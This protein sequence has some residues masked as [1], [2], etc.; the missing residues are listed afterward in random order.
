MFTY[1]IRNIL[2]IIGIIFS[3]F[4][5]PDG[6]LQVFECPVAVWSVVRDHLCSQRNGGCVLLTTNH[7][8]ETRFNQISC[9][10]SN[11][12]QLCL[13]CCEGY[14]R[15]G[16]LRF[17]FK[18]EIF[19]SCSEVLVA[20]SDNTVASNFSSFTCGPLEMGVVPCR[21][22]WFTLR[23]TAVVHHHIHKCISLCVNL[24]DVPPINLF[25]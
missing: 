13:L 16:N 8:T 19:Y 17:S 7:P 21:A 14:R 11:K 22:I 2:L 24:V 25:F 6:H 4:L 3:V 5:G 20:H 10:K 15:K 18:F 1:A 23:T 12:I 9:G